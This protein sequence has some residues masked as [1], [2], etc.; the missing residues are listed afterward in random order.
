MAN[1][2]AIGA[3]IYTSLAFIDLPVVEGTGTS[4]QDVGVGD[5]PAQWAANFEVRP[6]PIPDDEGAFVPWNAVD[7]ARAFG[8]VREFPNIGIPANVINVPQYGQATSSQITGQSDP[9]SMDF[10]FNYVPTQHFFIDTLRAEGTRR[11][12]RVRLANGEQVVATGG[13][14]NES[15]GTDPVGTS[16]VNLPYEKENDSGGSEMREFSDFYFF[17]SVASFE[18]VPALTDSNQLNVSLTIDGQLEGPFSYTTQAVVTNPPIYEKP[19]I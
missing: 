8:R 1:I 15:G 18:I 9:P 16:G 12:F 5:T 2:S 3:G 19:T 7:D 14:E 11:I 10:T 13:G 6:V 4:G 17:G